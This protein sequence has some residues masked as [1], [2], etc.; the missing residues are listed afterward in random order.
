[1]RFC[2]SSYSR[3]LHRDY[4]TTTTYLENSYDIQP[5]QTGWLKINLIEEYP[6]QA[7]SRKKKH[8]HKAPH[9]PYEPGS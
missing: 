9:P 4:P 2:I 8:G 3:R 1:M 5:I 6:Y 7:N